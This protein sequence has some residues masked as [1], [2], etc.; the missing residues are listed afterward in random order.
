LQF[1]RSAGTYGLKDFFDL[2]KIAN[3]R[4]DLCGRWKCALA[5]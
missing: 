4:F 5:C 1:D 3:A 2:R